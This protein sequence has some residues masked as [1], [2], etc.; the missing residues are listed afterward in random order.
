MK[1]VRPAPDTADREHDW[2]DTG[3]CG[4]H[5]DPDIWYAG[6]NGVEARAHTYEAQA[7]CRGCPVLEECGGWALDR[8]EPWG[9]WG[10]LTEGERRSILRQRGRGTGQARKQAV[11]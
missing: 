9:V 1:L 2:R 7:I 10:A 4:G 3:A 11:A 6:M 8:R 5:D